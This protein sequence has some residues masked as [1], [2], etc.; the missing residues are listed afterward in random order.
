MRWKATSICLFLAVGCARQVA[1]LPEQ[2]ATVKAIAPSLDERVERIHRHELTWRLPNSH[3]QT[4]SDDAKGMR[5]D[6]A[7]ASVLLE[8]RQLARSVTTVERGNLLEM[9]RSTA[10][11]FELSV[12]IARVLAACGVPRSA[13]EGAVDPTTAAWDGW[14]AVIREGQA[15]RELG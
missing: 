4:C 1:P 9:L 14:D 15:I 8:T 12:V 6:L 7:R 13:I 10:D 2:Y 5:L 3:A 11:E